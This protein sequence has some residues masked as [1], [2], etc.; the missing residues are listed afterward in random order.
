M[1]RSVI[2]IR[3]HFF[4]Y[5]PAIKDHQSPLLIVTTGSVVFV[6][7]PRRWRGP[8]RVHYQMP[9]VKLIHT[10][11]KRFSGMMPANRTRTS[12]IVTAGDQVIGIWKCFN[13]AR[14][15]SG[16]TRRALFRFDTQ[17]LMA[18][19]FI[20]LRARSVPMATRYW[21]EWI[22]VGPKHCT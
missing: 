21:N 9:S 14:A 17:Y 18:I 15:H 22:L 2:L 4:K 7:F 1:F 11:W 16:S 5:K 10:T 12:V 8:F 19:C 3:S 20:T 6:S 13:V